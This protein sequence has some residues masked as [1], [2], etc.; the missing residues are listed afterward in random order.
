MLFLIVFFKKKSQ[1][2]GRIK[3]FSYLCTR[4]SK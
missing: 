4:K 1:K 3:Y 2:F